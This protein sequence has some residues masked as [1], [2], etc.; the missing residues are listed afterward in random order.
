MTHSA[1]HV[2]VA[3]SLFAVGCGG[4]SQAAGPV[5]TVPTDLKD[6]EG[7]AEDAYDKA[8]AGDT[9]A[10]SADADTIASGWQAFRAQAESDGASGDVLDAMDA[11]TAGLTAAVGDG[12]SDLARAA[13][14][15][16]APMDE[17]FGLYQDPVPPAVLALDYLGREVALD[18][19]DGTFD[20]ASDD[21]TAI[22]T[23][24]GALRSELIDNGGDQEASDYDASVSKLQADIAAANA[25]QLEADANEGL[26]I[27]DAMEAVFAASAEAPGEVPD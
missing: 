19:R 4:S 16:S 21:V 1:T 7:L 20:R 8:L 3:I 9:A 14:A 15:I 17:L 2:L 10:V 12:S 24:Y 6:I 11:A 27:V 13:N 22:E 26:E 5:S 23:T 25:T 18:A